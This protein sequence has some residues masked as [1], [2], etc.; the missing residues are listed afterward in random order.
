MSLEYDVYLKN[1][2]RYVSEGL[3]WMIDNL[4]LR[5][6]GFSEDDISNALD[7]ASHHWRTRFWSA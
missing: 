4:P 5:D 6:L 7:E 2:I 1:H 3:R